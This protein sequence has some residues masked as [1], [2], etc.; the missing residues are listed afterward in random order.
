MTDNFSLNYDKISQI[1]K[2]NN[3]IM[4][5]DGNIDFIIKEIKNDRLVLAATKDG[6]VK[7]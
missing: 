4:A 6:I 3:H 1:S 5:D 7:R 2:K